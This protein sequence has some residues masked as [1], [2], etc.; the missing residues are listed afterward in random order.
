MKSSS[1]T[2][3]VMRRLFCMSICIC[4]QNLIV[5]F[6][7]YNKVA[8]EGNRIFADYSSQIL[9]DGKVIVI[10]YIKHDGI[11]SFYRH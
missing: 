10:I 7:R 6:Y 2:T 5:G 11:I 4:Y 9:K 8:G 1:S 3:M